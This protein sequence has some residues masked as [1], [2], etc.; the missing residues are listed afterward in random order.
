M[1]GWSASRDDSVVFAESQTYLDIFMLS[2]S[3]FLLRIVVK[4]WADLPQLRDCRDRSRYYHTRICLS[5]GSQSRTNIEITIHWP[6]YPLS[7]SRL[8]KTERVYTTN[9]EVAGSLGLLVEGIG[10]YAT[11]DFTDHS[12]CSTHFSRTMPT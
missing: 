3:H 2:V 4:W 5:L 10:C 8:G 9:H 12:R 6:E 1:R 7:L 11:V